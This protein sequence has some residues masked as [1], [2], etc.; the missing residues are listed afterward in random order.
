MTVDSGTY[1]LAIPDLTHYARFTMQAGAQDG[2]SMSSASS[3][4]QTATFKKTVMKLSGNVRWLAG[5]VFERNVDNGR[6]F[7]FKP[8]YE[9]VLKNPEFVKHD[10]KEVRTVTEKS[11]RLHPLTTS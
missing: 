3:Y 1:V 2:S 8:H 6:S 4:K 9:V 7:R 11:K 5:L 10:G